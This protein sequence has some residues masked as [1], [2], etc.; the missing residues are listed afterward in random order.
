MQVTKSSTEQKQYTKYNYISQYAS[1]N[2]ILYK[3][4]AGGG[5]NLDT[6]GSHVFDPFLAATVGF[7]GSLWFCK[8]L[9]SVASLVLSFDCEM[10]DKQRNGTKI[11][12]DEQ[13]MKGVLVLF[14]IE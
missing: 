3:K 13:L 14:S 2:S 9:V 7:T 5:W 4:V 12:L 10:V 6:N 11:V 8:I 1:L